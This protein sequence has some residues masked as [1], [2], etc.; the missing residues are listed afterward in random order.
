MEGREL[1]KGIDCVLTHREA[2]ECSDSSITGFNWSEVGRVGRL[3][4]EVK[5]KEAANS[6]RVNQSSLLACLKRR[7]T[8]MKA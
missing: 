1:M 4:T 2:H 6:I 8:S 5:K 7:Q 3:L